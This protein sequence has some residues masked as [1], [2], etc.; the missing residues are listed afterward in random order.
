MIEIDTKPIKDWQTFHK[1]FARQ[2]GFPGYYGCNMDA[3]IDCMTCLDDPYAGMT[4]IH[5][6]PP[7]LLVLQLG[8]ASDFK[9][10]CPDIFAS[11]VEC[12]AFVNWRRLEKK[13]PAVLAL[14]FYV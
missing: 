9:K 12:A 2:L 8:K 7:E 13:E 6:V 5:V 11:V 1:V 10:R 14:S 4:S 3:W